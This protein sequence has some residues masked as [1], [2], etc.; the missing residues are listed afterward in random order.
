MFMKY[1]NSGLVSP[2]YAT[3]DIAPLAIFL[4]SWCCYKCDV[5]ILPEFE[6]TEYLF[7]EHADKGKERWEIYAWALRDIMAREGGFGKSNIAVR[8]KVQYFHWM[9]M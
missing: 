1:D 6:P 4:L 7:T 9:S 3:M 8:K 2:S 5:T